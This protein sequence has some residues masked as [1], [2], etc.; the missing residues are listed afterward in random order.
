MQLWSCSV[1]LAEKKLFRKKK[2][3]TT[4]K[5]INSI[6]FDEHEWYLFHMFYLMMV[7]ET[8]DE[9]IFGCLIRYTLSATCHDYEKIWIDL[10]SSSIFCFYLIWFD[11]IFSFFHWNL[12]ERAIQLIWIPFGG[13]CLC[14]YIKSKVYL[15]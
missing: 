13:L 3:K 15:N 1:P 5:W 14:V 6:L 4:V 2:K 9:N 10:T 11:L 8:I 7:N 12:I